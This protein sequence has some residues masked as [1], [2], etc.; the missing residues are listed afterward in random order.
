M[1]QGM[2]WCCDGGHAERGAEADA[3]METM[4]KGRGT[5]CLLLSFVGRAGSM[6]E[7]MFKGGRSVLSLVL[8]E[9]LLFLCAQST[10]GSHGRGHVRRGRPELAVIQDNGQVGAGLGL[11]CNPMDGW[12]CARLWTGVFRVSCLG[13]WNNHEE[14]SRLSAVQICWL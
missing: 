10:S 9:G 4:L 8:K 1:G 14:F 11:M 6:K 12:V 13:V 3:V 7:V 2:R 5:W